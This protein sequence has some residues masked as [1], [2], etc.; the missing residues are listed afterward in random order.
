MQI[1]YPRNR[2]TDKVQ[3]IIRLIVGKIFDISATGLPVHRFVTTHEECTKK[4]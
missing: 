4:T 1:K 2:H 3:K